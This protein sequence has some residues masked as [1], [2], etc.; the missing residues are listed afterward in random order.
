MV[1]WWFRASNGTSLSK[2]HH[3]WRTGTSV[4]SALSSGRRI[5]LLGIACILSTLVVIG[6][7]PKVESGDKSAEKEQY[8]C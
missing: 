6:R 4:L 2:L 5:G 8:T 1:A 7:L 3:D